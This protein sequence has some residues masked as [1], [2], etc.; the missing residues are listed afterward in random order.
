MRTGE[1]TDRWTDKHE[2]ANSCFFTVL[3][4]RLKARNRVCLQEPAFAQLVKKLNFQQ[5]ST[6]KITCLY[7]NTSRCYSQELWGMIPKGGGPRFGTQWERYEGTYQPTISRSTNTVHCIGL[8]LSAH[9]IAILLAFFAYFSVSSYWMFCGSF[10]SYV[11]DV[12]PPLSSV[13]VTPSK[14][15]V[16]DFIRQAY[17][18]TRQQYLRFEWT[19][20]I[21]FSLKCVRLCGKVDKSCELL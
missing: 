17:H 8:Q 13:N 4:T 5:K 9:D 19:C 18:F 20:D 15:V 14:L 11:D 2:E 7:Q 21:S 12:S 10:F 3:R 1:E 16:L 6:V